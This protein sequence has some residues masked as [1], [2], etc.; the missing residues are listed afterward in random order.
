MA[1]NKMIVEQRKPVDWGGKRRFVAISFVCCPLS[2]IPYN[3]HCLF[4]T[5][6]KA[7]ECLEQNTSFY[8]HFNAWTNNRCSDKLTLLFTT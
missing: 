1:F 6:V 3:F 8:A 7:P 4:A 5:I 2:D